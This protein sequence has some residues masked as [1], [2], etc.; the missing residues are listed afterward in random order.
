MMT[1]T[2]A[3]TTLLNP[4]IISFDHKRYTVYLQSVR[5][6]TFSHCISVCKSF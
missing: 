3:E 2:N 4:N 5:F 6:S 1:K